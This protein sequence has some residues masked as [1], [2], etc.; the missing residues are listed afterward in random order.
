MRR[1]FARQPLNHGIRCL[2]LSRIKDLNLPGIGART[3]RGALPVKNHRD[4][5]ASPILVIPQFSHER[6]AGE[7]SPAGMQLAQFGPGENNAVPVND[8]ILRAHLR[9]PNILWLW[10][11]P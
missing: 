11:T 5:H 2:S 4:A 8:E 9:W 1:V 7:R 3:D 10:N 6:V